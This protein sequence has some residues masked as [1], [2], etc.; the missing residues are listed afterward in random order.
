MAGTKPSASETAS[1][2]ARLA[3]SVTVSLLTPFSDRATSSVVSAATVSD[4]TVVL[5]LSARCS[6][7][8]LSAMP[9]S[10][11]SAPRV[12]VSLP[13]LSVM[14]SA[15]TLV[16]VMFTPLM[17][18]VLAVARKESSP[19]VPLRVTKSVPPWPSIV[20]AAEKPAPQPSRMIVSSPVSPA[21]IVSVSVG[22]AKAKLSASGE[23]TLVC[24]PPL[25]RNVMVSPVVL[26]SR[27]TLAAVIFWVMGSIL[28]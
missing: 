3:V 1:V 11:P 28:A 12:T 5:A 2:P 23:I 27:L 21:L 15:S 18:T 22:L 4:K 26:K 13:S 6:V 8:T 24:P 16:R 20:S 10:K 9:A 7:A 19:L 25:S 17:V 14:E